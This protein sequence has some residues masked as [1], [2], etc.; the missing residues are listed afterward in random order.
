MANIGDIDLTRRSVVLGAAGAAA[1]GMPLVQVRRAGATPETMKA[2][3]HRLIGEAP[4]RQGRVTLD[5]PPLVENGNTIAMSVAV[6]SPTLASLR[7][8]QSGQQRRKPSGL[9]GLQQVMIEPG[10]ATLLLLVL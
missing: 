3:V 9:G 6:E 5:I 10:F 7:P 4:V 1:F 2:S 8:A